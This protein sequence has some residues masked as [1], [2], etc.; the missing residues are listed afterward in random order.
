LFYR[1]IVNCD[2]FGRFDGRPAVIKSRLFPLKEGIATKTID[3]AIN[4]LVTAGLVVLYVFEDKPYLQLSTW[5]KH[6]QIRA[7]RSKYP[8]PSDGILQSDIIC[9]QMISSDSKCPRNPIQS[10][11][12]PNPNR[13]SNPM[14]DKRARTRFAPPTLEE[15]AEYVAQRNSCVDPQAFIDFYEAKGWVVGKTPMKDWKAACRN[16]EHWDRWKK[17]PSQH[18][19][20]VFMEMLNEEG[21]I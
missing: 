2:D 10:E 16:A 19:G 17:K 18:S 6:Q 5:D 15:V 14:R 9:N 4:K 13:E 11:S 1:L 7:K 8:S 12:N 21:G 20:N 3:A